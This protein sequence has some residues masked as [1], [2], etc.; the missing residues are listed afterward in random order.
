MIAQHRESQLHDCLRR[1][2]VLAA[3]RLPGQS[4]SLL[5]PILLMRY[6]LPSRVCTLK[7]SL[8]HQ[9]QA[10]RLTPLHSSRYQNKPSPCPQQLQGQRLKRT[11]VPQS[12]ATRP[13]PTERSHQHFHHPINQQQLQI[14]KLATAR[15]PKN[16]QN[17]IM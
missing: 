1:E 7:A 17:Q 3:I 11:P 9:D 15:P 14:S 10:H 12:Q 6:N 2:A 13:L 16:R 8:L 5:L 4:R